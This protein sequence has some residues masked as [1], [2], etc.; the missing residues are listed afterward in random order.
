MQEDRNRNEQRRHD[1]SSSAYNEI[2]SVDRDVLM[3]DAGEAKPAEP[4]AE[5]AD[6]AAPAG[7]D[8]FDMFAE[9]DDDDMFAPEPPAAKQNAAATSAKAVPIVQAKQLDASL[10]DNW[11]DEEGYYKTIPG[12][13][14]DNRYRVQMGLGKGMFSSVVRALDMTTNTEVAIKVIRNNETM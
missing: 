14:L 6:A 9:G 1:V 8:D 12:E 2:K 4:E 5:P 11:D 13:L 3:P 7:D 10:L